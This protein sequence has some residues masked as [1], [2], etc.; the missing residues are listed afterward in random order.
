MKKIRSVALTFVLLLV[1]VSDGECFEFFENI[2]NLKLTHGT[3]FH[4]TTLKSIILF[5]TIFVL[6]VDD[7]QVSCQAWSKSV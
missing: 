6:G 3:M 4:R 7:S 5:Y 1:V 2:F